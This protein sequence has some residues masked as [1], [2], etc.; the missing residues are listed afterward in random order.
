MIRNILKFAVLLSIF[1][2]CEKIEDEKFQPLLGETSDKVI[3]SNGQGWEW[4]AS[5]HNLEMNIADANTSS[6]SLNLRQTIHLVKDGAIIKEAG[7]KVLSP[8]NNGITFVPATVSRSGND[9]ISEAVL[10]C[11]YDGYYSITP[12]IAIDQYEFYGEEQ[13]FSRSIEEMKPKAEKIV[14]DVEM[15]TNAH[16]I[17]AVV[18]TDGMVDRVDFTF[19]GITRPATK[20]GNR[21]TADYDLNE[22]AV[23]DG[24]QTDYNGIVF[25]ATNMFG[26]ATGNIRYAVR[27]LNVSEEISRQCTQDGMYDDYAII[28]GTKWAKGNLICKNGVWGFDNDP[29]DHELTQQDDRFQQYFSYGSTKADKDKYMSYE[30]L[31]DMPEHIGGDS[32]YD[33]AAANIPG[34]RLPNAGEAWQLLDASSQ[35]MCNNGMMVLP[36]NNSG[37]RFESSTP[38]TLE[39]VP[40]GGLFFPMG[41]YDSG[42]GVT[43]TETGAYLVDAKQYH[44]SYC[45]SFPLSSDYSVA[46]VYFSY[47]PDRYHETTYNLTWKYY[48]RPVYDK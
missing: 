5:F 17:T 33:V 21:F 37:K 10:Q 2:A 9:L 14:A 20:N 12:L 42:W 22:L 30:E 40:A 47:G 45:L 6:Y 35:Q 41:G 1:T 7:F 28:A 18:E 39:K 36:I 31:D 43:S 23:K 25:T 4:V 8:Q 24:R 26:Q 38:V 15:T 32:R 27:V 11:K 34:W 29:L 3:F 19:A 44:A 46:S 16:T 13:T 48:V